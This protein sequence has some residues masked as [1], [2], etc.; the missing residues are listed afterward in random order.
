MDFL[1]PKSVGLLSGS[2]LKICYSRGGKVGGGGEK[3]TD[4][5]EDLVEK[6]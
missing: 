1:A 5:I 6:L 2:L 4:N 3:L